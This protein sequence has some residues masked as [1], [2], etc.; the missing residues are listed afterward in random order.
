MKYLFET[1]WPV[2]IRVLPHTWRHSKEHLSWP[3]TGVQNYIYTPRF[4]PAWLALYLHVSTNRLKHQNWLVKTL[5][6]TEPRWFVHRSCF[7]TDI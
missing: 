7:Y 5:W 1:T 6:A 4:V 2:F 3:C